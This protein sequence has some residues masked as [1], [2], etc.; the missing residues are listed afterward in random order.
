MLQKVGLGT[1]K[2]STRKSKWLPFSFFIWNPVFH[3][4]LDQLPCKIGCRKN[5][6]GYCGLPLAHLNVFLV[7]QERR[8][9]EVSQ[10]EVLWLHVKGVSSDLGDPLPV[11]GHHGFVGHHLQQGTGLIEV[12][13]GLA[14]VQESLPFLQGL[15]QLATPGPHTRQ[16]QYPVQGNFVS[17]NSDNT[18]LLILT[19]LPSFRA[20]G[21]MRHLAHTHSNINTQYRETSYPL[22]QIIQSY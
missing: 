14:Q 18:E 19:R 10:Q 8:L 3:L 9:H 7:L 11:T 5:S 12:V 4:Q 16:H 13:D 2:S 6:H 15:G 17:M 22:T 20:L 1:L 21:S